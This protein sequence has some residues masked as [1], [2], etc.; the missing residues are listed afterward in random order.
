MHL[1]V[2]LQVILRPK[3]ATIKEVEKVQIDFLRL[4]YVL[5]VC[6]TGSESLVSIKPRVSTRGKKVICLK[7]T[8]GRKLGNEAQYKFIYSIQK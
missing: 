4:V 8:V 7:F 6:G 2:H 5:L 3:L 1:S